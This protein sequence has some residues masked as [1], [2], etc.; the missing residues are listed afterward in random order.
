MDLREIEISVI[1]YDSEYTKRSKDIKRNTWFSFPNDVLLHPDFTEINGEELKWFI[2]IVSICSKLNQNKIRLNINHAEKI[3]SLKRKDLF[4]M[5]DKLQGKQIDTDARPCGDRG[6]TDGGRDATSTLHYITLH[7]TTREQD[8]GESA[9]TPIGLNSSS[10]QKKDSSANF[11]HDQIAHVWSYYCEAKG[12][13][14]V[15]HWTKKRNAM[16]KIIAEKFSKEQLETAA[17]KIAESNFCRGENDRGWKASIDFFLNEQKIVKIL[18][19]AYDNKPQPSIGQV[20]KFVLE[21]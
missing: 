21:E 17:Q 9:L 14:K 19:G 20:K 1:K 11:A 16:A 6:A 2:W 7:N 15:I 18:E 10:P 13:S 8:S 3:V 12:F 4:S 5:I